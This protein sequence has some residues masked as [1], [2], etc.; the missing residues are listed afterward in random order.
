[1]GV[2]IEWRKEATEHTGSAEPVFVLVE[3]CL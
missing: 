3:L 1:M 2:L